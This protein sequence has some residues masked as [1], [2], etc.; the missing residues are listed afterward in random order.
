MSLLHGYFWDGGTGV[1]SE[2]KLGR[3]AG[4][5][6]HGMHRL[7]H[8]TS[9]LLQHRTT[10]AVYDDD[11]PDLDDV[12]AVAQFAVCLTGCSAAMPARVCVLQTGARAFQTGQ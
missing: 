10:Q 5:L 11:R 8:M 2:A 12:A 6:R 7:Y 3:A 4:G 1:P 9:L